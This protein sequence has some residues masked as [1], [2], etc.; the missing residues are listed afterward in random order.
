MHALQPHNAAASGHYE[1][2]RADTRGRL[3][4]GWL[5]AR[6]SFSFG[7]YRDPTRNRF[8]ALQALND[9]V[10]QPAAGF[11]MH[12]HQDLE[13]FILPLAG[14][15]EHRDSLGNHAI[16]RPGEV[17]K[18]TAGSGIWHSQM[19]ASSDEQ[20]HHL[21]IW[22]LP[23]TKGL[24][25]GIA[26]RR[27]DREGRIGRWQVL[28][29]EDGREDSLTVDQDAIVMRAALQGSGSLPYRTTEG[30]SAYL[31]VI[32]GEVWFRSDD[33]SLHTLVAGDAVAMP[34]NGSFTVEARSATA[35]I[36]LFDLPPL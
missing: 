19:N 34:D 32:E 33:G 16:V 14:A 28:I 1:I 36:L 17:Q 25:P 22:L 15:V 21:Q 30:R 23:R 13:I 24:Q 9:D 27:F 20:D 3:N 12:P 11:E 35:D 26:Q 6:F 18:M 5:D 8:S 10:I 2:R 7:P 31:H 4:N 29:S